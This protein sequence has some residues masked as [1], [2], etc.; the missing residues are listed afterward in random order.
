MHT[1]AT[2]RLQALIERAKELPICPGLSWDEPVWDVTSIAKVRAHKPRRFLL[3]FNRLATA[4]EGPPVPLP[5]PFGSFG[6][7]VVTHFRAKRRIGVDR[8]LRIVHALRY[9]C[10]A[11]LDSGG[12]A[13]PT[14][15]TK[16]HFRIAEE[17]IRE[18]AA[19]ETAC[20]A[21]QVLESVAAWMDAN[22]LTPVRLR[23][24]STTKRRRVGDPADPE[25]QERGLRKLPSQAA[26]EA[27]GDASAQPFDDGERIVLRTIDLLVVGGFRIGEALTLP[28]A[29]WVEV[30]E[31][32]PDGSVALDPRTGEPVVRYGIRY[33]PEKGGDPEPKW[34][35]TPAVPLARRAIQ[36]LTELCREARER[37]AVLEADP[38]RVPLPGEHGPEDLL[39]LQELQRLLGVDNAQSSA[40]A[41]SFLRQL[42]VEP[43]PQKEPRGS[44]GR[45]VKVFRVGDIERALAQRR[46][47]LVVLERANGKKQRLSESLCVVYDKA[48]SPGSIGDRLLVRLLGEHTIR[49]ALGGSVQR[50]ESVFSRRGLT[51]ADGSPIRIR[52]HAFR[53]WLNTLAD[54]GGL[55]DLLLARWMG[56]KDLRQNEAYK[57][58]T[59]AQRVRWVREMIETGGL[60]GPVAETYHGLDPV[61]RERFL[62]AQVHVVHFTPFG[63]CLHDYSMDPCAYHLRCLSGCLEY[64]RTKG[65]ARERAE[66]GKLEALLEK[67]IERYRDPVGRLPP[68][69]GP[70]LDHSLRQLHGV[71]AALA[72]D[73][74]E[75]ETHGAGETLRLGSDGF[76][77]TEVPVRRTPE[78]VRVFPGGQRPGR[79]GEGL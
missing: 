63:V 26:L 41:S 19:E 8:Q 43:R 20:Q 40:Q 49:V 27:L 46:H 61:T 59:V 55:S 53:H 2:E 24:R 75:A 35:P 60:T 45:R 62:E 7:C 33:W 70:F 58:G 13:D 50:S 68:D 78:R 16:G 42:G 39:S 36:E 69:G 57:H 10:Q 38:S 5:E 67:Q 32:G 54:H 73:A 4:C 17:R 51:E 48:F 31:V 28:A 37:A 56:R 23:Y 44:D 72:V 25:G 14:R 34:I 79:P 66:L 18:R 65:D 1:G 12:D 74:P 47:G 9:L 77:G 15:L 22:G 64:L 3:K 71:R 11:L 52:T 30:P 21:G 6:K 29:C 76:A